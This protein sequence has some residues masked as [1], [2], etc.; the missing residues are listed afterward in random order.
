LREIRPLEHGGN[1]RLRH[2]QAC[3][4]V[5]LPRFPAI[6]DQVGNQLDIVL[7][8][9]IAASLASLAKALDLRFRRHQRACRRRLIVEVVLA[10][11]AAFSGKLKES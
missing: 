1:R 10:H 3:G 6:V 11:E 4:D 5:N 7:D 8:Q 9:L 2:A